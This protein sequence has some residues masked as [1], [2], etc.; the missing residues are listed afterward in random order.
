VLVEVRQ[1]R[2]ARRV[3]VAPRVDVHRGARNLQEVKKR[4]WI[5]ASNKNSVSASR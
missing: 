1:A 5:L 4:Y 3:L 2:E